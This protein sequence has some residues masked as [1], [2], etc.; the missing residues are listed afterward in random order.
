MMT[1]SQSGHIRC[2]VCWV[3]GA[4][5]FITIEDM[6]VFCNVLCDSRSEALAAAKGKI[7]LHFCSNCGHVFNADF[8]PSRVEYTTR[9]E[10][11]L[12]YSPVFRAYLIDLAE[13]LVQ[14]Y[15][16]Y[17]KEI[18]EIGCGQGDFLRLLSEK[19]ANR[20]TGFEP[21]YDEQR[22][23]QKES[24]DHF[25]IVRD[26][27]SDKYSGVRADFIAC[28]QVLEHIAEPRKFMASIRRSIG[29][30]DA[31]VVF[32]EVPNAMFTLEKFGIWD[33][34]Y[35]HCGYYTKPSLHHLF[36]DTGLKPLSVADSFG[37]QYLCIEA[38]PL[39]ASSELE[40]PESLPSIGELAGYV[41]GFAERYSQTV[42]YW[43]ESLKKMLLRDIRPVVWGAGSKGVTFL[44][45]L[46]TA[47]IIDDVVDINP[48]KQGR[49]VPGSGQQVVSP[50]ALDDIR[51]KVVIAMNPL[52]TNEI[53]KMIGE[54]N[55]GK[56]GK[57]VVIPVDRINSDKNAVPC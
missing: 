51:P 3:A 28:R 34:I 20:C 40:L 37:G 1:Q 12:Q 13:Q 27:Y 9:Y 56:N 38:R 53:E 18:I 10:N 26:Y 47:G 14:R 29:R 50:E 31:T 5:E 24:G 45:V 42:S 17:K 55:H 46:R 57:L 22:T 23:A 2:P 8:D 21:A 54:R 49:Y 30:D 19:G 15:H 43:Q 36:T 35:E 4:E 52:Y 33:L 39:P 6:P 32:F 7:R 11:S 16:L 25:D 48:H 41:H 44:N